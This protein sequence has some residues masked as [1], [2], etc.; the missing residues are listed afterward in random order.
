M[1]FD[2]KLFEVVSGQRLVG[3]DVELDGRWFTKCS[4]ETCELIFR[5]EK[6]FGYAETQFRD[7]RFRLDD[8]AA[9]VAF[10]LARMFPDM[11]SEERIVA[12][13]QVA[14]TSGLRF[15]S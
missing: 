7:C 12:M 6:P 11:L 15:Q 5:G 2:D 8:R 10:S 1:N 14:A 3:E 13:L 9:M 4:Y